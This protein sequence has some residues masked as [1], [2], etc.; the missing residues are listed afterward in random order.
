M[1]NTITSL[2]HPT[3]IAKI[4]LAMRLA[5]MGKGEQMNGHGN[6]CYVPNRHGNNVLRVSWIPESKQFVIYGDQSREVSHLVKAAFQ[7]E[8]ASR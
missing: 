5:C 2:C 6:R 8:R 1:R 7:L 4:R 3:M